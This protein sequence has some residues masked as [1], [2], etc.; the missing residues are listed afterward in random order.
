MKPIVVVGSINMDLVTQADRIPR[1]GETVTGKDF[2]VHSGGKG[3]N[4]AV[5][6]AKLG[7]PCVLLGAVGDDVFGDKLLRTLRGYAVDTNYVREVVGSSG[8][9]S[10]IVN[11]NAENCIVV[12]PGA[13]VLVSEEYLI[14]HQHVI[15]S[16]GLVLLQLEIPIE[17]VEWVVRCCAENKIPV[18][19][20]P[21]PARPLSSEI[22]RSVDWFTPNQTEAEFY[23]D[24]ADGSTDEVVDKLFAMGIRNVILKRGAEGALV[25]RSAGQRSW[26]RAFKVAALDTTAAGDA[27]NGAFAVG[28]MRGMPVDECARFASA[29][30]ALAVTRCGAQPSL[31]TLKE[32][33]EFMAAHV[34]DPATVQRV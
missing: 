4:Q 24:S 28:L 26:T 19:L 9:A 33:S 2:Q 11:S 10:I 34:S 16:A 15:K 5:A 14:A 17:S 8:T 31:A 3:A 30:A 12:T 25:A 27:F 21:A 20:D 7:Y 18:M 23:T 22:M 13:N 32:V 29:A 6:V 1:L